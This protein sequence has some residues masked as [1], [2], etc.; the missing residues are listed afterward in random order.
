MANA[1]TAPQSAKCKG[2]FHTTSVHGIGGKKV[3]LIPDCITIND[4]T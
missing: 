3:L 1:L 4:K 2:N